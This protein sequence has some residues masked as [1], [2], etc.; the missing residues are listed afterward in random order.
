MQNRFSKIFSV[1]AFTFLLIVITLVSFKS[2]TEKAT[3]ESEY[4]SISYPAEWKIE[5][6]NDIVNIFPANEIGAIT[7]SG[8]EGVELNEDGIKKLLVDITGISE[9]EKNVTVKNKGGFA[10]FYHEY[11]DPKTNMYWITKVYKKNTDMHLVTMNCDAKY[12]NGN[13]RMMFLDALKSY[14]PKK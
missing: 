8:Y 6:D 14:K 9:L 5:N 12:W 11:E 10:E 2:S 3:F 13:Y 4:F 1:R 7:I